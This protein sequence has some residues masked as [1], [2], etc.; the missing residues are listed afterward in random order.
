MKRIDAL[1]TCVV[2]LFFFSPVSLPAQDKGHFQTVASVSYPCIGWG[3]RGTAE[4]SAGWRFN[5]GNYLGVGS[6]MHLVRH[7]YGMAHGPA[8]VT[9]HLKAL[10]FYADYIHYFR[11]GD[12]LNSF[13]LG[14]ELGGSYYLDVHPELEVERLSRFRPYMNTKVGLDIGINER[15]GVMFLG[16]NFITVPMQWEEVLISPCLGFRF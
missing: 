15:M 4:L 2:V 9:P 8:E 13:Y 3:E 6:G 14:Q 11:F 5:R 7:W 12:S 10:P 16:V 1:L